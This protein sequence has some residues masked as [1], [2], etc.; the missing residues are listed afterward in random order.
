METGTVRANFRTLKI[1]GLEGGVGAR[2]VAIRPRRVRGDA[3]VLQLGLLCG[4]SI[5]G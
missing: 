4:W 3:Q 5:R 2:A 1:V